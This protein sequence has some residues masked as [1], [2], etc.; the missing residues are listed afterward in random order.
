MLIYRGLIL[1]TSLTLEILA[2]IAMVVTLVVL[3][4]K[5]V[6]GRGNYKEPKSLVGKYAYAAKRG[7]C[8]LVDFTDETVKDPDDGLN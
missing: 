8:P 2:A 6:G 4:V 5:W 7:V 1:N 3:Y